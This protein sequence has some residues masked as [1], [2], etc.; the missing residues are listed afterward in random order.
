MGAPIQVMVPNRDLATLEGRAAKEQGLEKRISVARAGTLAPL[1]LEIP[2]DL[3][4][5]AFL[6]AAAVLVPKSKIAVKGVGLNPTRTAFLNV[7]KRMGGDLNW[8]VEEERGRE[9]VGS[10]TAKFSKLKG[11]KISGDI[12]SNLIDEL[13]LLACLA[14]CAE[15]TTVIRDAEEL[16]KKE[17]DRIAAVSAGLRK[18]GAKVGELEDGWAIEGPAELTGTDIETFGDHRIAMAFAVLGLVAEGETLIHRPECTD[19]SFPGF[20]NTLEGLAK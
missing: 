4:G 6:I 14:A 3:S 18:M 1:K 20:F 12:I 15:G 13:P 10:A 16:R 7:L 9:P 11:V 19:V 8:K 2:G 5:A 17:S